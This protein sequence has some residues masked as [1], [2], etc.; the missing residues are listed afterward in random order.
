MIR[1]EIPN[2][3]REVK[4]S[5]SQ[6]PKYYEWNPITDIITAKNKNLLQRFTRESNVHNE[7]SVNNLKDIY[8]VGIFFK[9]K[10]IG[11]ITSNG[12]SWVRKFYNQSY[13][14]PLNELK[15]YL[16]EKQSKDLILANPNQVGQPNIKPIKGQDIYSSGEHIRA[17]VISNIKR[18]FLKYIKDIPPITEFP[19]KMTLEIHDTIKAWTD[20]SNDDIGKAWDVDNRGYPYCK[21]LPDLLKQEGVIPD[22]DRLRVTQPPHAVFVPIEEGQMRK[23]VLIIEKDTRECIVNHP[24]YNGTVQRTLFKKV[25]IDVREE[26]V[27]KTR[28][29]KDIKKISFKK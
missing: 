19:L 1:I 29:K 13:N 8:C 24:V 5:E 23:L 9:K 10:I 7:Y 2:Y 3:I 20:N 15:Y 21:A 17:A 6:R 14:Y 18:S 22:D 27:V 16:I 26:G 4:L 12:V 25:K 11:E 28:R